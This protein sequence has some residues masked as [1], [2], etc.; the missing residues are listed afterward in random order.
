MNDSNHKKYIITIVALFVTILMATSG[1]TFGI[2]KATAE[3]DFIRIEKKVDRIDSLLTQVVITQ[4]VSMKE[5][6]HLKEDMAEYQKEIV[7]LHR[8]LNNFILK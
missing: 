5:L 4:N 2:I 8:K 3:Q 6:E 7:E 1:W